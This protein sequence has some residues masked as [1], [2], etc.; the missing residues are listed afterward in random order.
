MR[1]P[2]R[3][4]IK[5]ASIEQQIAIALGAN[6]SLGAASP[7]DTLVSALRH[8]ASGGYV[9]RRVSR[10]FRTPCFPAGAGP[11]FVNAV[12]ILA[13][14]SDPERILRHLHAVE[15]EL[16]RSR[17]ERWEARVVD[18][19]LLAVGQQVRPDA[20]TQIAWVNLPLDAQ[21]ARAPDGLVLPHPRIQD[22]PF[23]L[24]PWRDVAPGW[25]HPVSGLTVAQMAA[26]LPAADRAEVWPLR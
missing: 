6:L 23:V 9:L 1:I 3:K 11:D 18:L 24:I 8:V 2:Y 7:A 19:D 20:E 15:A 12:A 13:G 17:R 16:G 10:F 21:M 22:R 4:G 26:A 5:I 25:R 14:P